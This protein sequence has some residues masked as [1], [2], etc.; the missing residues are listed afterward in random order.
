MQ[1]C[2]LIFVFIQL[3]AN[4]KEMKTIFTFILLLVVS[5]SSFSQKTTATIQKPGILVA[6]GTIKS[7]S[8]SISKVYPNPVKDF[9]TVDIY[10]EMSGNIQISLF[11]IMGTEVKKW[12]SFYLSQG[13]QQFK[14][15][16]SFIKT[17]VYI[18]KISGLKQVCSQVIKKN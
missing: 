14:V 18:L 9:L 16:L 10:T 3:N 12:E 5:V 17:G 8:F 6:G 2:G 7:Q 13:D 1:L 11:N 4:R 15:D